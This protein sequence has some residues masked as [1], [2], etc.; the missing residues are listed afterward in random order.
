MKEKLEK[1]GTPILVP[2]G[3][4]IHVRCEIKDYKFVYGSDRWLVEP[5]EGTGSAWIQSF[6]EIK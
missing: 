2:M 5:V 4:G 6:K 3:N 1:I